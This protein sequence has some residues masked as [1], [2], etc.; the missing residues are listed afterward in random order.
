MIWGEER[1]DAGGAT[2]KGDAVRN[3]DEGKER[4][5]RGTG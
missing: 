2:N 4:S 3:E 1:E 5:V